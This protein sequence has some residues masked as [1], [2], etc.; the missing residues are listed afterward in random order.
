MAQ[1]YGSIDQEKRALLV[2]E[3]AN[4]DEVSPSLEPVQSRPAR[5]YTKIAIAAAFL[6]A[7]KATMLFTIHSWSHKHHHGFMPGTSVKGDL[8]PQP[9]PAAQPS[10]WSSLYDYAD[11]SI[12]SAKRL[13]GAVQIPT[14]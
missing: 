8:C 10:N 6:L 2:S 3:A 12:E 14:Q 7:F 4:N 11:F 9:G 1:Q 13:S 5:R